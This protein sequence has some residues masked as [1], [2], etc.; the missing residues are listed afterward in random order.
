[1]LKNTILT[2]KAVKTYITYAC[3]LKLTHRIRSSSV[4]KCDNSGNL[5]AEVDFHWLSAF[6]DNQW[7]YTLGPQMSG[8]LDLDSDL[9]LIVKPALENS[10]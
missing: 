5:C 7:R 6:S 1:M 10:S 8:A 9:S 4:G 3:M 2:P